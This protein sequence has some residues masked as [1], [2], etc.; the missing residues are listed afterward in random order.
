MA[1]LI[2]F[3]AAKRSVPTFQ[4]ICCKSPCYLINTVHKNSIPQGYSIVW[5]LKFCGV[6]RSSRVW[7]LAKTK[8]HNCSGG[9]TWGCLNSKS[10]V[11]EPCVCK[12]NCRDKHVEVQ[13]HKYQILGQTSI[14]SSCD[15]Q[16]GRSGTLSQSIKYM[17]VKKIGPC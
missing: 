14:F 3:R 12:F 2:W 6:G 16:W 13:L 9:L 8:L 17:T 11:I 15:D 7:L 1:K 5:S 4:I 10:T